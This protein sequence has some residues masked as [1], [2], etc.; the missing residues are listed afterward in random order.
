MSA[1]A[2]LAVVFAIWTGLAAFFITQSVVRRSLYDMPINWKMT[3]G[4]ELVYWYLWMLLAPGVLWFARRYR[5]SGTSKNSLLVHSGAGLVFSQGAIGHC[6]I[7]SLPMASVTFWPQ[8]LPSQL[9][10]Q[11]GGSLS[12]ALSCPG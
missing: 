9:V 3:V 6:E 4:Y 1:T 8:Y 11:H 2:A 7:V 5:L 10:P 12:D